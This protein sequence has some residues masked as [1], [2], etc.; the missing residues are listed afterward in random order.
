ML[1]NDAEFVLLTN[2]ECLKTGVPVK[3]DYHILI[4]GLQGEMDVTVGYHS[5][6]LHPGDMAIVSPNLIFSVD[7]TTADLA[8]RQLLF[9]KT[10]LY[11][12][13]IKEEVIDEL[14]YLHPE[15]PPVYPLGDD[16]L[17]GVQCKF[18]TLAEEYSSSR[19]FHFEVIRLVLTEL[20]YDYNRACEYCLLR[21]RKN[22]NRQ[23]QL[24]F[25]FKKLVDVQFL[26]LRTIADYA[27]LLGVTAKHLS[28]T[29]K[30]ETGKTALEIIHER[31]LLEMQYQLKYASLSVKE[32]AG[33]FKFDSA[34][35]FT[36][37][38]KLKTGLTPKAYRQLP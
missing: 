37:F 33:Y 36:R 20:L 9:T 13:H 4:L 35:H 23:Y 5:F 17:P 26:E 1:S 10:F 31:L 24:T 16:A 7:R 14:L 34:S 29:V 32:V 18:K 19:P 12:S 8:T 11:K 22:M 25:Q 2:N 38:F 3:N 15:Y 6:T 27:T 21:F 28:E 30:E